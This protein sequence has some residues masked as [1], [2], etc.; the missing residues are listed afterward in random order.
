MHI[1]NTD[2]LQ[3]PFRI[4][5]HRFKHSFQIITS[6]IQGQS[7]LWLFTFR[8]KTLEIVR[9]RIVVDAYVYRRDLRDMRVLLAIEE[10]VLRLGQ[11]GS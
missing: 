5:M 3:L 8:Y 10:V 6:L 1:H 2:L 7:G 4:L 11:G 9:A